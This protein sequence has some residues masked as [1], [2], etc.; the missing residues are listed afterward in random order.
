MSADNGAD[1]NV[2]DMQVLR[3]KQ[4]T[5]AN[6]AAEKLNSPHMFEM[7]AV[8]EDGKLACLTCTIMVSADTE[9]KTRNGSALVLCKLKWIVPKQLVIYAL[10]GDPLLETLD[11]N[12]RE[13]LAAAADRFA[14]SIDIDRLIRTYAEKGDDRV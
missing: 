5:G 2:M 8:T 12:K 10:L 1:D 9:L 7:A 13:L 3:A 14:E 11:L 4:A 6:I